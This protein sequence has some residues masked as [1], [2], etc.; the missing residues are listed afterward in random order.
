MIPIPG[1]ARLIAVAVV[2]AIVF[3]AGWKVNGWR[4]ESSYQREKAEIQR[5]E[6]E[7]LTA[8][9]AEIERLNKVDR[10]AAAAHQARVAL[11]NGAIDALRR[12]RDE[13][14]GKDTG[15]QGHPFTVGFVRELNRV[16]GTATPVPGGEAP[17]TRAAVVPG[18]PTAAAALTRDELL[19]WYERVA[20]Q[21]G[22]C[23]EQIS[24]IVQWGAHDNDRSDEDKHPR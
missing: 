24:G 11:L 10:K 23:R 7:R 19:T 2:G 22:R 17:E 3:G 21:Y 12:D 1:A 20:A 4:L 18:D 15:V 9:A 5:L 14:A 8:Y 6:T 16:S 13:N